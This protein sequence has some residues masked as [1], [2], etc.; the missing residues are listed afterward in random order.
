[1]STALVEETAHCLDIMRGTK[2]VKH[3]TETAFKDMT[4]FKSP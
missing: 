2:I 4:L 1:M 3:T